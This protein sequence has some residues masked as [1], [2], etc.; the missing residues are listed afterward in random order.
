MRRRTRNVRLILVT[1]L[2][3]GMTASPARP[4]ASAVRVADTSYELPGG[5]YVLR[6][7]AIVPAPP[8]AVWEAWTSSAGWMSWAVPFAVVD[9]RQGGA[10]ETSYDPGARAGDPAN[11]VNRILAFL[12]GR[13]LAFKAEKAPPGFPHAD[14]LD[15]LF[16]VVEIEPADPGSSRVT[17]SGIGYTDTAGHREMR[18]FFRRGNAWTLERLIQRFSSGPVDWRN[19]SPPSTTLE[20]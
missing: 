8:D 5:E 10:I 14:L 20:P 16:S 3:C 9:F 2:A 15:G 7:E 13:M 1:A 18:E 6:H 12:P 4:A 19:L 11:I 17:V